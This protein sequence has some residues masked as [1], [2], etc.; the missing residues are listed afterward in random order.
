MLPSLMIKLPSYFPVINMT[1]WIAV[2]IV[3]LAFMYLPIF[4]MLPKSMVNSIA[5]YLS[6]WSNY[7]KSLP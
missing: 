5:N 4:K 2:I 7:L 1:N 3:I 6:D